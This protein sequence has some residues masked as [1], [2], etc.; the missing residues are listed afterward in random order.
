MRQRAPHAREPAKSRPRAGR[1]GYGDGARAGNDVQREHAQTTWR[2]VAEGHA[3]RTRIAEQREDAGHVETTIERGVAE[4]R[5]AAEVNPEADRAGHQR[6]GEARLQ[7]RRV[8]IAHDAACEIDRRALPGTDVVGAE[9]FDQRAG[10]ARE[11]EAERGDAIGQVEQLERE[12]R[13]TGLRVG[14]L[15]ILA[16]DPR[17]GIRHGHRHGRLGSEHDG[18]GGEAL[19]TVSHGFA[20]SFPAKRPASAR[21]CQA[22][23]AGPLCIAATAGASAAGRPHHPGAPL[24][25]GASAR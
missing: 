1:L 25:L 16:E 3:D 5:E 11:V 15:R 14:A 12:Q 17:R 20:L 4:Q 9:H 21:T 10:I 7:S 13:R 6:R 23:S 8:E 19:E 2:R 24:S 18:A 22:P